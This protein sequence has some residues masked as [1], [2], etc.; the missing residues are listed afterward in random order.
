L[1]ETKTVAYYDTATIMAVKSFVVL[2]PGALLKLVLYTL[3]PEF[4]SDNSMTPSITAPSVTTLSLIIDYFNESRIFYY[5][6]EC[7]G[8]F[9]AT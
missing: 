3:P 8:A 9:L 1:P 7:S 4:L 6:A 2:A 5:H